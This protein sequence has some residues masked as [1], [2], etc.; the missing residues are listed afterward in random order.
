MYIP[1]LSISSQ[2]NATCQ[3]DLVVHH[4]RAFTGRCSSF[5]T[6]PSSAPQSSWRRTAAGILDSQPVRFSG[7]SEQ[8]GYDDTKKNMEE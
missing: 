3:A 5:R 8:A 2:A 7:L 6:A 4:A 1:L